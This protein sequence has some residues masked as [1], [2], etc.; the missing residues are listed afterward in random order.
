[1]EGRCHSSKSKVKILV[2][3]SGAKHAKKE[4]SPLK[5]TFFENCKFKIQNVL[6]IIY[7]QGSPRYFA[8][9]GLTLKIQ[10]FS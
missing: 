10:V 4:T 6:K 8:P 3:F 5:N 7:M 9:G 1:V 2:I